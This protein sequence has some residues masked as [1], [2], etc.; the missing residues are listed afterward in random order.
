VG[1]AVRYGQLLRNLG[2]SVALSIISISAGSTIAW[3]ADDPLRAVLQSRYAAM[4]TAMAAHDGAAIAAILAPDFVSVDVTAQSE[5]AAQMFTEVTASK[6]DPN[7]SSETTLISVVQAASAVTVEQRYDMKT[8]KTAAD[9]TRHN[10]ELV[11]LSTDTWVKPADV[12]LIERTVTNELSYF[13]DGQLVG[14]KQ[15]P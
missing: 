7:K 12:W 3:S 10:I 15:K 4:K 9:G 6:P 13:K 5:S 1:S 2:V 8:V 11:T 14:H